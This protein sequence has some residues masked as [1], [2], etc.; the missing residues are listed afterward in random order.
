MKGLTSKVG[1]LWVLLVW[2]AGLVALLAWQEPV[3]RQQVLAT[4][5]SEMQ[6]ELYRFRATLRGVLSTYE[7][8]PE[9]LAQQPTVTGFL[10][11]SRQKTEL[12]HINRYLEQTNRIMGAADIYLLDQQGTTIAASNWE[13]P[14]SFL[15]RNFSF[16]P[17][18]YKAKEGYA[19]RYFALGTT[20]LQR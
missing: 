3:V 12:H 9:L 2:S 6:G 1:W 14:Q 13:M 10:S 16:R 4:S 19:G 18:F 15:G 5:A 20:S 11:S 8:L 7:N 17:Y